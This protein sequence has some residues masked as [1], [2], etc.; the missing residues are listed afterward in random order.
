MNA[1]EPKKV[2]DNITLQE[3]AIVR[4]TLSAQKNYWG[5]LSSEGGAHLYVLI[6]PERLYNHDVLIIFWKKQSAKDWVVNPNR[7]C[8][9]KIIELWP[10]FW[11]G[12]VLFEYYEIA[13]E[14]HILFWSE[15]SLKNDSIWNAIIEMDE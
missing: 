11:N 1:W 10:R 8:W 3:R 2:E 6:E 14:Y 15:T 7:R 12:L 5:T 13:V 9:H 4:R